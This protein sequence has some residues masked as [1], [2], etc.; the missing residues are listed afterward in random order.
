MEKWTDRA[1]TFLISRIQKACRAAISI[2]NKTLTKPPEK[3]KKKKEKEKRNNNN[4]VDI[5]YHTQAIY[6]EKYHQGPFWGISD[7]PFPKS[8]NL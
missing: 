7:G 2:P 1:E 3:G 8:T 6:I 4:I 5:L